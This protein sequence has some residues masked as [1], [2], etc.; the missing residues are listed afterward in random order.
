M[1]RS[2]V[3]LVRLVWNSVEFCGDAGGA[4]GLGSDCGYRRRTSLALIS[5]LQNA[6]LV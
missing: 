4:R 2:S 6:Q 1:H 5:R 3:I